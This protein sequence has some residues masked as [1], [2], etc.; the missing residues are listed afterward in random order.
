MRE[1]MRKEDGKWK[2]F[3]DRMNR[4]YRMMAE[5]RN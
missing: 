4:I 2:R 5:R 1:V 3:L